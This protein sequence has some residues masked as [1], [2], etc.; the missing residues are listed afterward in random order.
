MTVEPTSRA[1]QYSGVAPPGAH[2]DGSGASFAL[3]SRVAEAV[4][5]CLFDDSGQETRWS[6]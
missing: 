4:E 3:F 5:L 6:L 2:H 1:L